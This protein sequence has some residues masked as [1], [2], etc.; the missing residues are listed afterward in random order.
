MTDREDRTTNPVKQFDGAEE[1]GFLRE[2]FQR[3]VAPPD[4]PAELR[5]R[6]MEVTVVPTNRVSAR[7]PFDGLRVSS[8][9]LAG[10]G[11][12]AIVITLVAGSLYM[13]SVRPQASTQPLPSG[14]APAP[15]V[16]PASSS[17]T[18]TVDSFGRVDAS[19]TYA[20]WGATLYVS[21]DDG[22]T[23]QLHGLP[24]G[25]RPVFPVASNGWGLLSTFV[26]KGQLL[27]GAQ[28]GATSIGEWQTTLYRSRDG[29]AT[30]TDSLLPLTFA[31]PPILQAFDGQ[32]AWVS[33]IP[34]FSM[35]S[36]GFQ[37][38]PP[39][40]PP[41]V[42]PDRNVAEVLLATSDGGGAWQR[43][44][45]FG[46]AAHPFFVSLTE[47]WA[48]TTSGALVHTQDGGV[49]W[50]TSGTMPVPAGYS[51]A[52]FADMAPLEISG[53]LTIHGVAG[54]ANGDGDPVWLT[55]TSIDG[56]AN[57]SIASNAVFTSDHSVVPELPSTDPASVWRASHLA[58]E[59]G[60]TA[61]VAAVDGKSTLRVKLSDL[62]GQLESLSASAD[63]TILAGVGVVCAS[64]PAAGTMDGSATGLA[65]NLCRYLYSTTD[66]GQHWRPL[67]GAPTS[68]P[69]AQAASTPAKW[70]GPAVYV[71]NLGQ[72]GPQFAWAIS[73]D[74]LLTT[75][76]EGATW[77]ANHMAIPPLGGSSGYAPL[78]VFTDPDHVFYVLPIATSPTTSRLV[79]Y[80]SADGGRSWTWT[81]IPGYH[82][83]WLKLDM[84]DTEHGWLAT[85]TTG[86]EMDL[87]ATTDG[88]QTWNSGGQVPIYLASFEFLT[89]QE[90]W[91]FGY[92]GEPSA[93]LP[94][95]HTTDAGRTWTAGKL[96]LPSDLAGSIIEGRSD[97]G[98][99]A[100]GGSLRYTLVDAP[101]PL[102]FNTP[103][104]SQVIVWTTSDG[105]A[106]WSLTSSTSVSGSQPVLV[107]PAASLNSSKHFVV[108]KPDGSLSAPDSMPSQPAQAFPTTALAFA[109]GEAWV[110]MF[111][112]GPITGQS[113]ICTTKGCLGPLVLYGTSDGGRTWEPLL[114]TP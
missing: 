79:F 38:A 31:S 6:L 90:G 66:A 45:G 29:G 82:S 71:N 11:V 22:V 39:S 110:T 14:S 64:Y 9:A 114:G 68:P 78:P 84:L 106:T 83:D 24:D 93:S 103:P 2:T 88:G 57:W 43:V 108:V 95:F 17:Y 73:G 53:R 60:G 85:Q 80:R 51:I 4:V 111:D 59:A 89:P 20:V 33:V 97:L 47:A 36:G 25:L 98:P 112:H 16:S 30:W 62:P 105:G 52:W 86:S 49:S 3:L 91:V 28:S 5:A 109:D 42:G 61:D 55:W 13:R 94:F 100:E 70:T 102:A 15:N 21:H 1:D 87:L 7:W 69:G 23:W 26:P 35:T 101:D 34:S 81:A 32:S 104:A 41:V 76:D 77:A 67:L 92:E 37:H 99:T 10:L 96:P 113:A 27:G 18:T 75:H 65:S 46:V 63:G 8:R 48:E 50:H 107:G 74:T 40:S 19:F 54:P 58:L 44:G 56:G 12:T 72:L